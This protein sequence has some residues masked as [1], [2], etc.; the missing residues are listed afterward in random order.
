MKTIKLEIADICC[1]SCKH[2]ESTEL[3]CMIDR[4]DKIRQDY[5]LRKYEPIR[6]KEIEV[7]YD[8]RED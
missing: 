6:P 7:V 3:K 8:S 1:G 5:C 2:F 4:L